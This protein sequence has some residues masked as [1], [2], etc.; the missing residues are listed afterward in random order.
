MSTACLQSL[1]HCYSSE[2]TYTGKV[3]HCCDVVKIVMSL[4]FWSASMSS[5]EIPKL[6]IM[7]WEIIIKQKFYVILKP[8]NWFKSNLMRLYLNLSCPAV[9]H[10]CN[11]IFCPD[12]SIIL[13][14]NSTPIVCGQSAIT[15]IEENKSW[16]IQC[17]LWRLTKCKVHWF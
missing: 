1:L 4:K 3:L 14:P 12:T 15:V 17:N 13:V 9:S 16:N 2:T 7:Q 10:I 6:I 8:E 5:R 11:L